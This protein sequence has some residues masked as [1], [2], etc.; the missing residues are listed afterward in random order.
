MFASIS[1][2]ST[3]KKFIFLYVLSL[4]LMLLIMALVYNMYITYLSNVV[5]DLARNSVMIHDTFSLRQSIVPLIKDDV[6]EI[7]IYN[8]D[9]ISIFEHSQIASA[10]LTWD[11]LYKVIEKEKLL[12][13][14][15][16][17]MSLQKYILIFFYLS[18]LMLF[19]YYP[20]LSYEKKEIRNQNNQFLVSIS[21]KLA[22][23]IRSP[24]STLNLISSKIA[25]PDLKELQRAVVTQ[26]NFIADDLLS[27]NKEQGKNPDPIARQTYADLLSQIQKEYSLKF[28]HPNVSIVFQ[29]D[30][31]LKKLPAVHSKILYPIICNLI[32][33]SVE[34]INPEIGKIEIKSR[35]NV[36]VLMIVVKD[37]GIGIPEDILVKLGRQFISHGKSE[38]LASGNGMALFNARNDIIKIGGSFNI[39]SVINEYTKVE[40]SIPI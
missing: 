23:D 40:I 22:H 11:K 24:I 7:K 3:V 34:A 17:K 37:N 19:S 15:S 25:D 39:K 10:I 18:V 4:T 16:L 26:I 20:F 8:A 38:S 6:L 27:S 13:K 2:N 30:A 21:K 1:I 32:N 5:R 29:I 31:M 33:N 35:L 14:F 28:T 12:Y 9:N 36:D